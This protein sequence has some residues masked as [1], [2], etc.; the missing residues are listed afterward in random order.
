MTEAGARRGLDWFRYQDLP[1][2]TLTFARNMSPVELLTRMGVDADTLALR[3]DDEFFDAFGED[4][5]DDEEPVVESGMHGVWACA[6]ER[7]GEH[8]LDDGILRRV[9][10][11]TESAVIHHNEKPMDW[12]KYAVDSEVVVDFDTLQAIEPAGTD[13]AALDGI[14]R[15]LGLVPGDVAPTHGVLAL[16]EA[17]G[18]GMPQAEDPGRRWSG[19]LLPLTR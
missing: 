14:M 2:Y 15:P 11:G 18:A 4:L 12:F 8:G 19:R 10:L 6:W 3:D 1:F 9:S 5:Y 17:L 13:P 7:G 16:V